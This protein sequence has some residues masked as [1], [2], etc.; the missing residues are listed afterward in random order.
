[1]YKNVQLITKEEL[2]TQVINLN[3]INDFSTEKIRI[4][5][6]G[7]TTYPEWKIVLIVVMSIIGAG[8]LGAAGLFAFK[9]WKAKRS[10]GFEEQRS[11]LLTESNS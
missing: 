3:L 7:T 8:I 11:S 1:M 6:H 2:P 5:L 10:G 4:Y 9:F